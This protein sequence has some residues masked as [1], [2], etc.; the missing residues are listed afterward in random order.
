MRRFSDAAS[1]SVCYWRA[2]L[3]AV[4]TRRTLTGDPRVAVEHALGVVHD[5]SDSGGGAGGGG[6]VR[7]NEFDIDH[8]L[9]R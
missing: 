7:V 2:E 8:G 3:D 1:A 9:S 5:L 4:R 6:S